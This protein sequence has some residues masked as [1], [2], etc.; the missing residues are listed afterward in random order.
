MP[1]SNKTFENYFILVNQ[2]PISVR[3]DSKLNIHIYKQNRSKTGMMEYWRSVFQGQ[4]HYFLH[5]HQK[6]Q[7]WNKS[8]IDWEICM[9][10]LFMRRALK[11]QRSE[12]VFA[13]G[14][15]L[16][17]L[18]EL[19]NTASTE[20][21]CWNYKITKCHYKFTKYKG[22]DL[23]FSLQFSRIEKYRLCRAIMLGPTERQNIS[24]SDFGKKAKYQLGYCCI[25]QK[26]DYTLL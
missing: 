7:S 18:A 21:F 15:F 14:I 8:N 13:D 19:R 20:N 10:E 12:S 11:I 24:L 3:S 4:L 6:G 23:D 5:N 1:S 25:H 2:Q 17:N 26:S 22:G 16:F 9:V